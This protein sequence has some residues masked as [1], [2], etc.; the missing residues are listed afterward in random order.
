[1]P[2]DIII[3]DSRVEYLLELFEKDID[4]EGYLIEAESGV[5]VDALDGD[6][7][8][9]SDLGGVGHGSEIFIRNDITSIVEYASMVREHE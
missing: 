4:D 9:L 2:H 7:I 1:M 3:E 6:P 8:K 5:R